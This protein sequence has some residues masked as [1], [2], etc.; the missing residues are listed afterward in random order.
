MF[1]CCFAILMI[2]ES[3]KSIRFNKALGGQFGFLTSL[4]VQSTRILVCIDLMRRPFERLWICPSKEW[5]NLLR[6]LLAMQ[7]AP[8]CMHLLENAAEDWTFQKYSFA[9]EKCH[10]IFCVLVL[11][12]GVCNKR[13][14]IHNKLLDY[15]LRCLFV[16]CNRVT[17]FGFFALSKIL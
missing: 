15:F 14:F 3:P 8:D 11:L 9:L 5:L 13:N 4:K 16:F 2:V 17:N 10:K 12:C 7:T 6:F 1:G